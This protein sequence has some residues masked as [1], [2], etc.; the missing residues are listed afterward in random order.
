MVRVEFE[1]S[2]IVWLAKSD[3]VY[4]TKRVSGRPRGGASS[5][6]DT[7][8]EELKTPESVGKADVLLKGVDVGGSKDAD[9]EDDGVSVDD[10]PSVRSGIKPE[11][12][13]LGNTSPT[14]LTTA[15][16]A[17]GI[18]SVAEGAVESGFSVST[19]VTWPAAS[20]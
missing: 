2:A 7:L 5:Q 4:A 10:A 9:K 16:T 8:D 15:E 18:S 3:G 19:L 17:A 6:Q 20:M 1:K 11:R 14:A 13:T 12:D